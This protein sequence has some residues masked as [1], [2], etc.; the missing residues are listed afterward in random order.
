MGVEIVES[1]TRNG[2]QYHT[3]RNLSKGETVN[4][5]DERCVSV[6]QHEHTPP[7]VELS[8]QLRQIH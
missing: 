3:I 8:D 5:G 1:E 2:M 6:V 7:A 4:E